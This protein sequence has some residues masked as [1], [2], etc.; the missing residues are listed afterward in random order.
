M[1]ASLFVPQLWP[2]PH[3]EPTYYDYPRPEGL[4]LV[5]LCSEGRPSPPAPHC[6][7]AR[8]LRGP[9]GPSRCCC[10]VQLL[11]ADGL[12]C[13]AA[14][15]RP[16]RQHSRFLR[17][18]AENSDRRP[19]WWGIERSTQAHGIGAPSDAGCGPAPRITRLAP[20]QLNLALNPGE[21]LGVQIVVDYRHCGGRP[22][23][24]L[25]KELGAPRSSVCWHPLRPC[26]GARPSYFVTPVAVVLLRVCLEPG[27]CGRRGSFRHTV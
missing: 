13:A 12:P 22:P 8:S 9:H 20:I 23:C 18:S 3:T 14:A 24:R 5:L 19:E 1:V 15:G 25:R 11:A 21:A 4:E 16:L 2:D 10:E 26:R 7:P 6:W 17:R 27:S